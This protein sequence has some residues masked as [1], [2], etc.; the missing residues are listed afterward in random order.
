MKPSA[1]P[2]RRAWSNGS[3]KRAREPALARRIEEGGLEIGRPSHVLGRNAASTSRRARL[4]RARTFL[5]R[6][7]PARF[8]RSLRRPAETPSSH[9]PAGA[10]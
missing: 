3:I 10:E 4:S 1:F 7:S 6:I 5:S 2:L 9:P 8:A